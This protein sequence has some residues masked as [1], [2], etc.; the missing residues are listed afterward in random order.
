MMDRLQ[1]TQ[2]HRPL[3]ETMFDHADEKNVLNKNALH[4]FKLLKNKNNK[5][6]R[7]W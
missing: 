3:R 6:V 2:A 5:K 7:P 1:L 4:C